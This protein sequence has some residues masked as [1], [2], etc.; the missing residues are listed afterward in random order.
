MKLKNRLLMLLSMVFI[1]SNANAVDYAQGDDVLTGDVKL[2]CEAVLCLSSGTRPSECAA[3][4]SRYFGINKKFWSDTVKAR[5]NFL[6]ICPA[7]KEPKMPELINAISNGAGRCDADYLNKNLYETKRVERCS[8]SGKDPSCWYETY[9]RIS[10]KLPN[11]CKVYVSHEY[12]DLN[13][14]VTYKGDSK[15]IKKN[16]YDDQQKNYGKWINKKY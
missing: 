8:G 16:S 6:N 14:T 13:D 12:T 9:F 11:Y 10:D 2:A 15:W 4:L 3:S 1:V 7:S 5:R